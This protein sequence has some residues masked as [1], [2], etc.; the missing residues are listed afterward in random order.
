MLAFIAST[1]L[2]SARWQLTHLGAVSLLN[3]AAASRVAAEPDVFE[4]AAVFEFVEAAFAFAGAVELS[5][6][7]VR[8]ALV[9]VVSVT[10]QAALRR[11]ASET[12]NP[13]L[14][15]FIQKSPFDLQ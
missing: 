9:L 3:S 7:A 14:R 13:D 15:D 6:G 11:T 12:T 1:P 5:V 2:P 10:V 4:F 8:L